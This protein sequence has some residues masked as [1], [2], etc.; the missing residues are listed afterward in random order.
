MVSPGDLQSEL[1]R[2]LQVLEERFGADLVSVV[3]FGSRRGGPPGPTA[4][5]TSSSWR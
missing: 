4:T 1:D 2:Y 3:L 5:S